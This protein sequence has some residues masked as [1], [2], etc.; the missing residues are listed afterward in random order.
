M[1]RYIW[2]TFIIQAYQNSILKI[3]NVI[4]PKFEAHI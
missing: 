2:Y 4:D 3:S 1:F